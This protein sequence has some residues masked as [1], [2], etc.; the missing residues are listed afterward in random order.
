MVK[1]AG[2]SEIYAE[3]VKKPVSDEELAE[4]YKKFAEIISIGDKEVLAQT[5]KLTKD[6]KSY[7]EENKRLFENRF[8]EDFSKM[9]ARD[10]IWLGFADILIENGYAEE[11]DWK[12]ELETFEYCFKKLKQFSMV[13]ANLKFPEFDEEADI[14]DWIDELNGVFSDDGVSVMQPDI[15][16]DSYILFPIRGKFSK[17]LEIES[18]KIGKRFMDLI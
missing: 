8:I 13:Y 6:V 5:E 4:A 10:L 17:E 2:L 3:A 16:S 12:C 7:F 9:P 18:R 14:S 11:F 15:D 1:K